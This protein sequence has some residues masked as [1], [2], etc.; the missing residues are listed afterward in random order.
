MTLLKYLNPFILIFYHH[1]LSSY[2]IAITTPT[3]EHGGR[4]A[5]PPGDLSHGGEESGRK[6]ARPLSCLRGKQTISPKKYH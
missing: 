6:G 1:I 2:F 4:L 5:P 3:V